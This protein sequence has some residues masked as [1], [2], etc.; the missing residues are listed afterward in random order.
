MGQRA[1][2]SAQGPRKGR[3]QP[4]QGHLECRAEDLKVTGQTGSFFC[5]ALCMWCSCFCVALYT[6][7]CPS[8]CGWCFRLSA[9]ANLGFSMNSLKTGNGT[10]NT[11]GLEGVVKRSPLGCI[12][13]HRKQIGCSGGSLARKWLTEFGNQWYTVY[14]R[15]SGEMAKKWDK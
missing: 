5:L 4:L 10:S 1:A 3:R 2:G 9:V 7:L 11:S 14:S 8:L 12:L 6:C 15:G 13:S